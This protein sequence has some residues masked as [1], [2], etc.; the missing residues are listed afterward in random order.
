MYL[1]SSPRSCSHAAPSSSGSP[2]RGLYGISRSAPSP[3]NARRDI[4]P[5]DFIS[6]QWWYGRAMYEPSGSTSWKVSRATS[7]LSQRAS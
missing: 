4:A 7:A 6:F 3:A 5:S 1:E 2:A